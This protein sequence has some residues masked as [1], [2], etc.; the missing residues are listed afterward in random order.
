MKTANPWTRL[1]LASGV[2]AF[3]AG[4][5]AEEI[6]SATSPVWTPGGHYTAELNLNQAQ[7]TLLPLSG[8]DARLGLAH[9]CAPGRS[10]DEGVYV[11]Q[12]EGGRWMLQRTHP[13]GQLFSLGSEYLPLAACEDPAAPRDALRLPQQAIHAL[14]QAAVGAIYI[15]H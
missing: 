5:S 10:V 12:A 1:L 9:V 2:A 6:D 11:L 14:E 3:A 7:L 15:H 8:E 4:A 13:N